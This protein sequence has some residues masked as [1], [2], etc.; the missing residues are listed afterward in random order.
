MKFN[1][2]SWEEFFEWEYKRENHIK[3]LQEDNKELELT[4]LKNE[5]TIEEYEEVV[6]NHLRNI[7]NYI[8]NSVSNQ[9]SVRSEALT[10]MIDNLHIAFEQLKN[11][12][13]E[14]SDE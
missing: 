9:E 13:A 7:N 10:K 6:D 8:V 1:F 5:R 2:E 3:E 14:N 4:R 12:T 11:A